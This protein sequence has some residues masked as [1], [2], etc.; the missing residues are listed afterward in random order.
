MFKGQIMCNNNP[1]K[2]YTVIVDGKSSTTDDAGIFNTAIKSD[3]TQVNIQASGN[4]YIIIYP[5]GGRGLIPKD[6]NL[7]TQIVVEPFKSNNYLN[8]YLTQFRQLKDSSGKSRAELKAVHKQIDSITKILY[9]FNYT[10]EDL[11]SAQERQN[12][13]DIYYPEISTTLQNYVNQA[14]NVSSAFKF[15]AAYA[16]D[17]HNALEQIVQAINNYNP[18]F[19]KLYTNY[20]VYA[21]KIRTY[22]QDENLT[23]EYEGIAD[24]LVNVIH[25][26]TIFPLNDL[27]TRINQYFMG[28]ISND[29]KESSKKNIQAQIAVIIPKLNDQ[30]AAMERRIQIFENQLK[31]TGIN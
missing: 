13:T 8:Q 23:K 26:Q 27:K 19:D 2:N 25:R 6:P 24:T 21:Q 15:I 10:N 28:Q 11:R 5:K 17:N 12:G 9:K 31:R 20:N 14:I 16:F 29:D 18:A 7:I 22:W 1:V 3:A 4:Q 30:L